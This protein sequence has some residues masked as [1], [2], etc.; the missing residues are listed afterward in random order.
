MN[1][2]KDLM[3]QN[4]WVPD[5]K[6]PKKG[7]VLRLSEE[8][9][10][11]LDTDLDTD[12]RLM[13]NP[14]TRNLD[15]PLNKRPPYSYTD[16]QRLWV[17]VETMLQRGANT[18]TQ[19]AKGLGIPRAQAK[20]FIEE[21]KD[22][23]SRSLTEGQVNVRREAIYLEAERVKERCWTMLEEA[24]TDSFRIAYLRMILEAGA[25][26]SKLIGAEKINVAVESKE[27]SHKSEDAIAEEA[28]SKLQIPIETL[29]SIGEMLSREI[30]ARRLT[31]EGEDNE[32]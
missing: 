26:Q 27:V 1:R 13:L 7:E 22:A 3:G 11:D 19:I 18:T 24:V 20:I 9:L 30:T 25:R 8:E 10:L 6:K 15:I 17:A 16:K 12:P 23:W 14:L 4:I 5:K 31:K 2:K 29:T 28:A 21:V 32:P